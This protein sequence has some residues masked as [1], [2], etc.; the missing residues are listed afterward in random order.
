MLYNHGEPLTLGADREFWWSETGRTS[1]TDW[2]D[3]TEQ[4]DMNRLTGLL[5]QH[6]QNL[7]ESCFGF[8]YWWHMCI[9]FTYLALR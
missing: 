1:W 9:G 6:T 4:V 7:T 2:K 5:S 3:I 8:F